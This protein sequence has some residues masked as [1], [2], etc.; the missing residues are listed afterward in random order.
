MDFLKKPVNAKAAMIFIC[1]AVIIFLFLVLNCRDEGIFISCPYFSDII[2][3]KISAP[4]KPFEPALIKKFF[5]E[6]DFKNY[7]AEA[8]SA[9]YGDF[10]IGMGRGGTEVMAIEGGAKGV[11]SP[12]SSFAAPDRVSET[13]VQVAGIDE[14][15]IVKTDGK[16]IYFSPGYV[17]GGWRGISLEEETRFLPPD[18]YRLGIQ[19]IK[20]FPPADLK[21]DATIS[22]SG[23]DLLLVKDILVVFSDQEIKGFD[24]KDPKSPAKKW[25]VKLEVHTSLVGSRLYSGKVYL[26]T[27]QNINQIKPCPI[28]PLTFG[29]TT[30][31][32]KCPDIY[33]PVS[34]VSTDVIFTAMILDPSTGKIE[35]PVSFIGSSGSSVIYMSENAI[36]AT[37]SYYES[38]IKFSFNFFASWRIFNFLNNLSNGSPINCLK[39]FS[40]L[41]TDHNISRLFCV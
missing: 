9:S 27:R 33:H 36:Y 15:D 39:F 21:I 40:Q 20:A 34:P 8:E 12:L 17:W 2:P 7:L 1:V 22:D 37:Y 10:G 29:G 19:T 4:Q 32:I 23:G 30:L 3:S 28:R 25:E 5:S 26:I 11:P 14:P 41:T 35:T 16:E 6:E 24:V 38:I 31:E 13:N 18:R